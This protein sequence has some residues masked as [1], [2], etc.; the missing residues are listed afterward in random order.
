MKYVLQR[1]VKFSWIVF[2]DVRII[3][4]RVNANRIIIEM[5]LMLNIYNI[6][7][8]KCMIIYAI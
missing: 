8:K 4:R 2:W 3:K 5:D 6:L 7:D 1:G